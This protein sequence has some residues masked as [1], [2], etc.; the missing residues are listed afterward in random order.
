MQIANLCKNF[1]LKVSIMIL[2]MMVACYGLAPAYHE[3]VMDSIVGV[4]IQ[5]LFELLGAHHL[6]NL[7]I[8]ALIG[9]LFIWI[10][11]HWYVD[12]DHRWYRPLILLFC[13]QIIYH[14]NPW[15]FVEIAYGIDYRGYLTILLSILGCVLI[16]KKG[17]EK[18]PKGN[19]EF[20][21]KYFSVDNTDPNLISDDLHHYANTI[22]SH[23]LGTNL[24]LQSFAIGITG[25]WGGG[26]STFMELLAREMDGKAEIVRFNPWMCRTPEQVIDDFFV[27]LRQQLSEKHSKL[28]RSIRDYAR[29][30][31]STT[32]SF[33]GGFW[34]KLA[35]S[36]PEESFLEK[37]KHL[38]E[39]FCELQKP[40][41]IFIDDLDRLDRDEVF[42]ILRLIRN[43][44][45]LCN[46]IYIAAYDKDYVTAVLSEKNV[47]DAN[48]YLE[49]I[50]PVE[51]HQPKTEDTQ[52]QRVLREELSSQKKY[53]DRLANGLFLRISQS[54]Q[55][56]LL[57]ILGNYRRVKRFARAYLLNVDF[58]LNNFRKEFKLL[59]LLWL[60]LLQMY[61]KKI[62]DLLSQ[63]PLALLYV[64]GEQYLLKPGIKDDYIFEEDESHK[65]SGE[66]IWK[67]KTPELLD[68]LFGRSGELTKQSIRFVE[69]YS[70]YFTLG[71]SSF[72]LSFA[73]F[74]LL[75]LGDE[76]V[77]DVMA[78]WI[79]SD[80]KYFS[81]VA[82]HFEKAD[83]KGYK[84]VEFMRYITGILELAYYVGIARGSIER[85]VKSM[86]IKERFSE[87]QQGKARGYVLGWFCH[88]FD[89]GAD[90]QVLSLLLHRLYQIKEY[91][92]EGDYIPPKLL[93]LSNS[94]IELLL[95]FLM[96]TYLKNH[97]KSTCVDVLN[98]KGE[99]G[100]IFANCCVLIDEGRPMGEMNDY[101]QIAFPIIVK[102]FEEKTKPTLYEYDVAKSKM[103]ADLSQRY[104]GYEEYYDYGM[105]DYEDAMNA[106]FGSDSYWKEEFKKRCFA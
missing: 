67:P 45:D 38:S 36:L 49:K 96:E 55:A 27:T 30:I 87:I 12:E 91:D 58:I 14:N 99:L 103:F 90:L 104:R 68:I 106:Y 33:G 41:V 84:D 66:I 83:P 44:A 9:L 78:K 73:D 23:L 95:K 61:D 8:T 11:W 76:S 80:R 89:H 92:L 19:R 39:K 101:K 25:E 7:T 20:T 43:T 42:E 86:L 54:Q 37:K 31:G 46:V 3:W 24:N 79:N 93:V 21:G 94:D 10:G 60:E 59:D 51:V 40:V 18:S 102:Y 100:K 29:Y 15:D 28:S 4:W 88:K 56:I 69:N 13:I 52:L 22:V 62:Y 75:I 35:L 85:R 74:D 26:K 1:D 6:F 77:E 105:E 63:E 97:P 98:E 48:A 57:D 65:Y 5:W 32:F 2:F 53:G 16:I 34:S 64:H 70:N 50:F 81:S 47:K 17:R 82:Y 71:V 72:K